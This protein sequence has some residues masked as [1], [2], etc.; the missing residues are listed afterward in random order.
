M[1]TGI[2]PSWCHHLWRWRARPARSGGA[3]RGRSGGLGSWPWWPERGG[4]ARPSARRTRH[5]PPPRWLAP[6]GGR[7]GCSDCACPLRD[8]RDP[9]RPAFEVAVEARRAEV[10]APQEPDVMG[11]TVLL[12]GDQG[13]E[14]SA[15][16][17]GGCQGDRDLLFP[18]LLRGADRRDEIVFA[19]IYPLP[20]AR[21]RGQLPAG[22]GWRVR[23]MPSPP[24]A[25]RKK[26]R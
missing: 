8:G 14:I 25:D 26:F 18:G 17:L 1:V 2:T 21:S 13:G 10:G 23:S 7:T 4:R 12:A 20:G 24:R 15:A 16:L 11:V 6:R 5:R 22:A 9:R 19:H 3:G